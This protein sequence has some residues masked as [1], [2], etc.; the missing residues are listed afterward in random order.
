MANYTV[1]VSYIS[2][3]AKTAVKYF[4]VFE[5]DSLTFGVGSTTGFNYPSQLLTAL[6]Y[7]AS[8]LSSVNVSI[9]G[10]TLATMTAEAAAQVD[11]LYAPNTAQL[12]CLIL[13]GGT[14]D[15]GVGTA[16]SG[17]TTYASL[18][19]Y[20]QA[21]RL[22][23]WKVV[24]LTCLPRTWPGDPVDFE[25]QRTAFNTLIRANYATFADGLADVA[26]DSRI[27]DSGDQNDSTYFSGDTT[28]LTNTGYAIISSIVL[29]VVGSL[30]Y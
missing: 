24:V 6:A 9:G 11:S 21:R 3:P 20:C 23:G 5:G 19:S 29:P 15:M 28:H 7:P 8:A 4:Y 12:R 30:H 25:T 16:L 17:A 10:A 14:N 22:V 27:G 2:G 26:A 1:G 18:V 13:W